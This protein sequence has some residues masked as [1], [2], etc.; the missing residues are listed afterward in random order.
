MRLFFGLPLDPTTTLQI[1]D[2][3]DRQ[4]ACAGTPV[5]PGNFHITLAFIG[6]LADPATERLCLSV[7]DWL[8][9]E[10]V[11]GGTLQLDA[12]GYWQKPG[13]YWL[14]AHRWPEQLTRLAQKLGNLG[15]AAGARR[16]RNP[17]QPHV[18]L[19]RRCQA[20]PPAAMQTPAISVSYRG[21]ALFES[22]QGKRGVSYHMLQDWLLKRPLEH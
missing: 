11:S 1:A 4:L 14:G 10:T 18:S 13:I 21:F 6:A 20:A 12:T 7:D 17:F 16:D 15:G 22:R 9:H 5:P 2:W 19:F 8:A 3:R